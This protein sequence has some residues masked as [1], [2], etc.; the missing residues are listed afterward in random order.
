MQAGGRSRRPSSGTLPERQPSR[1]ISRPEVRAE[2]R[3]LEVA[4]HQHHHRVVAELPLEAIVGLRGV[5]GARHQRVGAG[6]RLEPAAPAPR[7]RARAPPR[8]RSSAAAG[9]RT[10]ARQRAKLT[11]SPHAV[12]LVSG[13]AAHC[14]SGRIGLQARD[15]ARAGPTRRPSGRLLAARR[16]LPGPRSGEDESLDD[17]CAPPA[18]GWGRRARSRGYGRRV[19]AQVAAEHRQAAGQLRVGAGLGVGVGAVGLQPARIG[20]EHLGVQRVGRAQVVQRGRCRPI[21]GSVAWVAAASLAKK[22]RDLAP[23]QAQVGERPGCSVRRNGSS[24]RSSGRV[25]S[26]VRSSAGRPVARHRDQRPEIAE[27]PAQVGGQGAQLVSVGD[28]SR[29]AGR[30]WSISGSV[31]TANSVTPRA[32]RASRAGRSGRRRS[33]LPAR[34]RGRRWS[35][36]RGWSSRSARRSWPWRSVSAPNTTPVSR[37]RPGWPRS[38][39]SRIARTASTSRRTA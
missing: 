26:R 11:A 34:G 5:G 32:W 2:H 31:F 35:R 19:L 8:R 20:G 17:L 9:G 18:R 7:R 36:T 27:Q 39:R 28:S 37:T 15:S 25:S 24:R 14:Y 1:R 33:C 3:A 4:L 21:E 23:V 6:A 29:A 12:S 13:V 30:S 16:R 22:R 10:R 38:W